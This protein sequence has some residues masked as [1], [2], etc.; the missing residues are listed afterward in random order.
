MGLEDLNPLDNEESGSKA[1]EISDE[2]F[3]DQVKKAQKTQKALK[4]AEGKARAKDDRLAKVI[5]KFLQTQS[6]TAVM[7]LISRCLDHNI[8]AGLILGILAL[9]E[10][11]AQKEF[12]VVLG[13]SAQ[14]LEAPQ[15]DKRE[16]V[17][18][19][20][21]PPH[22][23]QATD[24]WGFGLLEFGLTQPTRLLATAVSPEGELFPSLLKL[25]S[26][27]LRE[28]LEKEKVEIEFAKIQTF[29]EFILQGVLKRISK[30]MEE[31]RE[32]K[33]EGN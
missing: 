29:S 30:Q 16:I 9:V 3:R 2:V 18:A 25:T 27:I 21:F 6:N 31:T 20:E 8:P 13:E 17:K 11:E 1:T 23:K 12:E 5:G 28:Y 7:L 15:V 33:E 26:F 24:V 4:K 22:I 14:L 10:P 32:L 19:G